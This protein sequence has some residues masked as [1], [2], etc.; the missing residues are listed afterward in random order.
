MLSGAR[1]CCCELFTGGGEVCAGVGDQVEGV[2]GD[3]WEPTWSVA[4]ARVLRRR[5]Q[6]EHNAAGP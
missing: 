1:D 3:V 4:L 2:R 5:S 6:L